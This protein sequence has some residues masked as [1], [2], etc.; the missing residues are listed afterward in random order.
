MTIMF[1]LGRKFR[2]GINGSFKF[3]GNLPAIVTPINYA[4]VVIVS[5]AHC[6]KRSFL[7]PLEYPIALAAC[8]PTNTVGHLCFP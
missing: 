6:P 1:V 7:F 2:M 8:F 5:V 3:S 4:N